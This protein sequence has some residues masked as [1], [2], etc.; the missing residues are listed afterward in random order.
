MANIKN[1]LFSFEARNSIGQ[2]ITFTKRR[3]QN[4]AEIKPVVPDQKTPPQIEQRSNFTDCI[5]DWRA[6]SAATKKIWERVATPHH[7]TGYAW[8]MRDCLLTP[9]P[10]PP[11]PVEDTF[12]PALDGFAGHSEPGLTW[13]QIVNAAGNTHDDD[14]QFSQMVDIWNYDCPNNFRFNTRGILIFDTTSIPAVDT[15]V[16]ATL[17]LYLIYQLDNLVCAP[18]ICVYSANPANNNVL[19]NA[20]YRACGNVPWATALPYASWVLNGFNDLVFVQAGLDGITKEGLTKLSVRNAN[21]DVA[22][23]LDPGNH[24]PNCVASKDSYFYAYMVEKGNPFRPELV[25]SHIPG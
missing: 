11:P 10:P 14:D 5:E 15:I 20:D 9:A 19:V 22:E 1:P 6:L 2:A 13:A 7:M 24:K 12:Y 25:V 4:I 17:R 23:E 16:G 3:G 21:Y 8:F 18:D